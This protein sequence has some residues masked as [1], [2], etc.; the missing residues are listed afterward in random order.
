MENVDIRRTYLRHNVV[1]HMKGQNLSIE[2]TQAQAHELNALFK[3]VNPVPN[4]QTL[5][6]M[7]ADILAGAAEKETDRIGARHLASALSEMVY[8]VTHLSPEEYDGSHRCR[9]SKDTLARAR[10]ALAF[11]ANQENSHD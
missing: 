2:L 1:F 5:L 7:I 10:A 9:I 3:Q 8:E 6:R 4:C 11:A